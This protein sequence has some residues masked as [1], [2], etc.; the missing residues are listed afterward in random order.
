MW[1]ALY[2]VLRQQTSR[3]CAIIAHT[4]EAAVAELD[5]GG[6]V[7]DSLALGAV[8][9]A[10]GNSGMVLSQVLR[11]VAESTVDS[12]IDGAVFARKRAFAREKG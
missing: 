12:V 5:N 4:M 6:D 11:G 1:L 8:R 7:A 2:D 3:P 10:R 9:G